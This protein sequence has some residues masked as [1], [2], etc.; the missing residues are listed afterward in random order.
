MAEISKPDYTYLW[1]SGGAIVAPSNVKIQT[2]WTAEVPPFQWENWSQNRQ[3]A[4]IS[5]I[6][7]K[8]IS[9][10]SATGEYYFTTS[11]ERSYVQGS[12]GNIY[13]AVADS[14]GQNP[15]T[16]TVDAYWK[17]AFIDSASLATAQALNGP[18]V[19]QT[20]NLKMSVTTASATASITAE[21]VVVSTALGGVPYK[22]TNV[23]KPINLSTI[24]AGGMDVGTAPASGFVSI[25]L[26]YNPTT[27]ASALLACNQTTSSGTLY[28]GAN[29]PSGYTA[30]ALVGAWPTNASSLFPVGFQV[31]RQINIA[32]TLLNSSTAN[33]TDTLV[34]ISSIVPTAARSISGIMQ[35]GS[36]AQSNC[37]MSLSGAVGSI[38]MRSVGGV[39]IAAGNHQA[40]Y[41]DLDLITATTI[42]YTASTD[43]GALS[44][45]AWVTS[46]KI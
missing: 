5:H 12:D 3:D 32:L 2:G 15:V 37:R 23:S 4:A 19:G 33:Q 24:G 40:S 38:G 20:T 27:Q 11:G 39:V 13:V 44:S 45:S 28:S 7:Q 18:P 29:M 6:L 34:G 41:S 10:W 30:S 8:G 35:V 31:G 16:D 42:Y 26:I 22:L 21:S 43:T 1:S 46:Y 17:I 36:S 25:Y 9:V 14:V